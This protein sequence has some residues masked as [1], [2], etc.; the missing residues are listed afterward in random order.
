MLS[1]PAPSSSSS[2]A[3][4]D[5]P[6]LNSESAMH[7]SDSDPDPAVTAQAL[8]FL[9]EVINSPDLMLADDSF[10]TSPSMHSLFSPASAFSADT[11][12]LFLHDSITPSDLD[13]P[14]FDTPSLASVS[15]SGPSPADLLTSPALVDF[16]NDFEFNDMPLFPLD[17][18]GL[19]ANV[20]AAVAAAATINTHTAQS[21]GQVSN[22]SPAVGNTL[23]LIGLQTSLPSMSPCLVSPSPTS[24]SSEL[25]DSGRISKKPRLPQRLTTGA[26]P[27]GHRRNITSSSLVPIDAPTQ[28]RQYYSPSSTSRKDIPAAFANRVLTITQKR[29]AQAA[30]L[31]DTLVDDS[32]MD[33]IE[34]KRRQNTLAARRSRQR[35]LD[36]V[37]NLEQLLARMTEDRDIWKQRALRAEQ[38]VN[39]SS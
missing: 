35:K 18:P 31:D 6:C 26:L 23:S 33:A 29:T 28:I 27:T 38:L 20:A 21:P 13:T 11:S 39:E 14:L 22:G 8:R 3:F 12:P 36:H 19:S 32:L 4:R 2:P 17:D 15:T 34:A 7:S 10:A 24:P 25:S 9:D 16:D 30:S 5:D 1:Q 37:R